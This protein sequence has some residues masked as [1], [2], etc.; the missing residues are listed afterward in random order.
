[1]VKSTPAVDFSSSADRFWLL[2][3]LIVPTLRLPGSL[4]AAAITSATER[5][6]DCALVTRTKSKKATLETGA[7]SVTGSNGS[8]LNSGTLMAVPLVSSASV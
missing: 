7:K 2:P 4:R 8:F 3:I 5:S 6:G 1:M